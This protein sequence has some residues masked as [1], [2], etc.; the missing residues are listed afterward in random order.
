MQLLTKHTDY[1]IRALLTLAGHADTYLSARRIAEEQQIPYQFLRGLLQELARA[2]FISSREGAH[3]GVKLC[4]AP[5]TISVREV[6]ELFQGRV[7]LSECMFRKQMCANRANCVLRH[8][9][10]KIERMVSAEFDKVTVG[11]LLADLQEVNRRGAQKA[12]LGDAL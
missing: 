6:I 7:E 10:M 9:I 5:E 4:K 8:Q 11:S 12:A 3:G 2:G 1:A